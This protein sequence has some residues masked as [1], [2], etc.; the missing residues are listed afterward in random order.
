MGAEE[1]GAALSTED[2]L[3]RQAELRE[4]A[5]EQRTVDAS[6]VAPSELGQ[7][8]LADAIVRLDGKLDHMREVVHR[9]RDVVRPVL[10]GSEPSDTSPMESLDVAAS[11]PV[12]ARLDAMTREAQATIDH[13]MET[14]ERLRI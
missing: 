4:L 5:R 9:L 12:S 8:E 1:V 6:I 2:L 14:I 10:S 7:S 3:A 11:T 13:L